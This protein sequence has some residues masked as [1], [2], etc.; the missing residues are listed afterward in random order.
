MPN[1]LARDSN[2]ETATS[3]TP[4]SLHLEPDPIQRDRVLGAGRASKCFVQE[5]QSKKQTFNE[6]TAR[7]CKG[8]RSNLSVAAA[9]SPPVSCSARL[10]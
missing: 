4:N 2:K 6:L 3:K 1:F 8:H 5:Q 7:L 10:T 9:T